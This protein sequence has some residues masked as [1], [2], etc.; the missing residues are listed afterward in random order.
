MSA[1]HQEAE[2]RIAHVLQVVP[3][4]PRWRAVSSISWARS[5]RDPARLLV[6]I[7]AVRELLLDDVDLGRRP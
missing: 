3:P 2:C 1:E 4:M 7:F 5:M 6:D